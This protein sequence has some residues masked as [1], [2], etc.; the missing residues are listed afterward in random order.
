MDNK[1]LG[2]IL[3]N[4][5]ITNKLLQADIA[6]ITNKSTSAVSRYEKGEAEIPATV[7]IDICQ[8]FN[9]SIDQLLDIKHPISGI[10]ND[11]IQLLHNAPDID[12]NSIKNYLE[13]INTINTNISLVLD[14]E[15]HRMEQITRHINNT[16]YNTHAIRV[17]QYYQKLASAGTGEIIFQDMPI[18]RIEIPDI[19]EYKRVSYAIGVKGHS[20]EPL[21]ND[22]DMLLVEPICQIE[23][24]EIGI[25][26]IDDKA[27]VKKLGEKELISLNKGY[28]NIPLTNDTKCMGRV[29]DKINENSET[30]TIK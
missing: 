20:M 6:N 5:R 23:I 11:I 21:Y 9:I 22:G 4:F 3:K 14:K 7:I 12:I 30:K 26:I 16:K 28:N 18:D 2:L 13:I 27:Y 24:G 10:E 25:F 15:I 29:V 8:H 19:P 1:N 17:I